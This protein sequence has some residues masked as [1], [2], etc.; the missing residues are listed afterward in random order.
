MGYITIILTDWQKW[1]GG[2]WRV[3]STRYS[4]IIYILF[5]FIHYLPSLADNDIFYFF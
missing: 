3:V 5:F 4:H 2:G 1:R